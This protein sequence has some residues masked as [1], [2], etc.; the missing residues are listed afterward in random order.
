MKLILIMA[1]TADGRIART[2][3]EVVDWTGKA[4]K[5]YF[6]SVTRRAGVMIMG[7]TTFDMIGKV[8]PGRK[9]VVMTNNPDRVSDDPNLVYT[10]QTP[11]QILLDLEKQGY[12]SATVIGGSIVNSLFMAK[13]LVDEVHL[14]VVPLM[15]GSGL[16]LFNR[17]LDIKLEL[18]DFKAIEKDCLLLRYKVKP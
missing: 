4:D 6:V 8:L 1:V 14:T 3:R 13:G 15:F 18:I 7:S 16:G 9:S 2:S 12:T 5:K 10:D 17:D 11:E